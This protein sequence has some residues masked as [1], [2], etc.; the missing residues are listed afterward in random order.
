[1]SEKSLGPVIDKYERLNEV[2]N[3]AGNEVEF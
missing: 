3:I 2:I 1:M